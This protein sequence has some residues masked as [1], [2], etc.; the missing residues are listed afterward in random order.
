M[1]WTAVRRT[2]IKWMQPIF[3]HHEETTKLHKNSTTHSEFLFLRCAHSSLRLC[4]PCLIAALRDRRQSPYHFSVSRLPRYPVQALLMLWS[5]GMW[6]STSS[7]LIRVSSREMS[8]L[9]CRLRPFAT[10]IQHKI[11]LSVDMR[12]LCTVTERYS[13][14]CVGCFDH[15]TTT[16][17][18]N[19]KK[20]EKV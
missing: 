2:L 3:Y 15:R 1:I 4:N 18:E 19:V 8:Q 5:S 16:K 17:M 20:S 6:R 11:Y 10:L 12:M 14:F 9:G 13:L 7:M